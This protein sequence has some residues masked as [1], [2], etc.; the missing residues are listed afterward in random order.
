MHPVS[1]MPIRVLHT[2]IIAAIMKIAISN[3]WKRMATIRLLPPFKS[4][5]NKVHYNLFENY[6]FSTT[7]T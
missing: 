5:S 1:Q 4:V 2:V 3:F 7:Q 6:Q